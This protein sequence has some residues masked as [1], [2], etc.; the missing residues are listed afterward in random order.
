MNQSPQVYSDENQQMESG[1]HLAL[2]LLE[3]STLHS[4]VTVISYVQHVLGMNA[5]CPTCFYDVPNASKDD[6]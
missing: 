3:I 4:H 1:H 2:V 5:V 6:E